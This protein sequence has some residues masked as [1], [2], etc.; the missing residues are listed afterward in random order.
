VFIVAYHETT[1]LYARSCIAMAASAS[2]WVSSGVLAEAMPAVPRDPTQ[3]QQMRFTVPADPFEAQFTYQ[4]LPNGKSAFANAGFAIGGRIYSTH[5]DVPAIADYSPFTGCRHALTLGDIVTRTTNV[6]VGFHVGGDSEPK[7]HAAKGAKRI[8]REKDDFRYH[9]SEGTMAFPDPVDKPARTIIT[10]EGGSTVSRTKHV[11]REPDGHL[12]RLIPEE[13]EEL[14][15]FPRGF[16]EH[17]DASD[18]IR[19]FLMGNALVVGL[20]TRIATAL[21]RAHQSGANAV[22]TDVAAVAC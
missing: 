20:V 16:T 18:S 12:R 2:N 8:A 1:A 17:P 3:A 5:V 9:Y 4:P 21:H 6:P 10:S 22:E 19:A 14:N 7:W 15:G 13:L 11:V